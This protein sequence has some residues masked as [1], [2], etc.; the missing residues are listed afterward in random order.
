MTIKFCVSISQIHVTDGTSA[1]VHA[2][3]PDGYQPSLDDPAPDSDDR[4]VDGFQDCPGEC[5]PVTQDEMLRR[6]G[7][8]PTAGF[9]QFPTGTILKGPT[10]TILKGEDEDEDEGGAQGPPLIPVFVDPGHHYPVTAVGKGMPLQ[11]G[12]LPPFPQG[13]SK[14]ARKREHARRKRLLQ[15]VSLYQLSNRQYQEMTKVYSTRARGKHRAR[16]LGRPLVHANEALTLHP[17]HHPTVLGALAHAVVYLWHWAVLKRLTFH[18]DVRYDRL[19]RFRHR[20]RAAAKIAKGIRQ[21]LRTIEAP[22]TRLHGRVVLVWGNGS[23]GPTSRGHAAAPNK[24]L[25]KRL[26]AHF[27]IVLCSEYRTSKV[28]GGPGCA[29][30]L[31]YDWTLR[32]KYTRKWPIHGRSRCTTC[33]TM[34]ARDVSSGL[35]IGKV[36]THHGLHQNLLRPEAYRVQPRAGH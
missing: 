7:G 26:S 21:A 16:R 29:G 1:R 18:R 32:G 20:Q 4:C 2:F 3:R 30:L 24:S 31:K 22:E 34:W 10:G 25:R 19:D 12:D 33:H 6:C 28:C 14:R 15:G 36:W 17:T 9:R 13:L 11:K 27:P 8:N 23:F 5:V 35:S